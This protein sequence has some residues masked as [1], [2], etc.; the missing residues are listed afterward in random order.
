MIT[1]NELNALLAKDSNDYTTADIDAL[2]QSFA[3]MS[4]A[5]LSVAQDTSYSELMP[6][7]Y[8]EF[9]LKAHPINQDEFHAGVA[10]EGHLPD[11]S[12]IDDFA[13]KYIGGV[14]SSSI[15]TAIYDT[16]IAFD[17]EVKVIKQ[18]T[19]PYKQAWYISLGNNLYLS[20]VIKDLTIPTT[21]DKAQ[22][23]EFKTREKAEDQLKKVRNIIPFQTAVKNA[24]LRVE[25]K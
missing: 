12:P 3:D 13:V 20:N 8:M 24:L 17:D 9:R 15:Y 10:F 11:Q 18:R 22:R 23:I 14:F 7:M 19:T 5:I 4:Q 25:L 21:S 1:P 2:K 6:T 16:K